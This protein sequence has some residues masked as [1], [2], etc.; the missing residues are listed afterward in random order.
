MTKACSL[1]VIIPAYDENKNLEVLIPQVSTQLKNLGIQNSQILV[2]MRAHE[3]DDSLRQIQ[4]LGAVAIRRIGDD[5]FGSA[6]KTGIAY[7]EIITTLKLML[8]GGVQY[9]III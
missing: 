5:N 3:A 1:T 8:T 6:I 4:S 9:Q 7:S 2:V